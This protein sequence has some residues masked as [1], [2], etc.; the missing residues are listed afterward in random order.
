MHLFINVLMSIFIYLY[1]ELLCSR[2]VLLTGTDIEQK[3]EEIR[4]VI[5]YIQ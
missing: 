1:L 5:Q 3:R 2:T 4:K